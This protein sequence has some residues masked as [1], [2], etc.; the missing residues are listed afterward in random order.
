MGPAVYYARVVGVLVSA[1]DGLNR[2]GQSAAAAAAVADERG[3]AGLGSK[4]QGHT[5]V[6]IFGDDWMQRRPR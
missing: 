3:A 1:I 5:A 4:P 2:A 6:T